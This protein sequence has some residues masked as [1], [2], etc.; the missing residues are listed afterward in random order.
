MINLRS[1]SI[2]KHYLLILFPYLLAINVPIFG[3]V[4]PR[5]KP[6]ETK[7]LIVMVSNHHEEFIYYQPDLFT[8]QTYFVIAN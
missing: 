5:H 3:K 2:N 7:S 6:G 1:S 4:L 8:T